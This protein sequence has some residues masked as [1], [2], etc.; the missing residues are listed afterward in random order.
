[1]GDEVLQTSINE[2]S[3][4]NR[5]REHSSITE[6][7]SSK[8]NSV[9]SQSEDCQSPSDTIFVQEDV[10]KDTEK[11]FHHK[12]NISELRESSQMDIFLNQFIKPEIKVN[13]IIR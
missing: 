4:I 12:V 8:Q 3:E 11:G 6:N 13:K 2:N 9:F 7:R 5:A 10:N 1:M